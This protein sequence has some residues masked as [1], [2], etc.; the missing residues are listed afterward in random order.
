VALSGDVGAITKA[1]GRPHDTGGTGSGGRPEETCKTGVDK[2]LQGN[3]I[4]AE[5]IYI[6]KFFPS[7]SLVH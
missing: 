7:L 5:T 4:M 3:K 6:M 2:C 1:V